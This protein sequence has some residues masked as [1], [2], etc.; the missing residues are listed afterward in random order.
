MVDPRLSG[1]PRTSRTEDKTSAVGLTFVIFNAYKGPLEIT[2][3][4]WSVGNTFLP[5]RVLCSLLVLERRTPT[6]RTLLT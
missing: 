3:L 4:G 2:V 1:E 5:D 6:N